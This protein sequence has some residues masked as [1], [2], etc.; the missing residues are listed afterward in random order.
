ML[1][2]NRGK[3][4]LVNFCHDQKKIYLNDVLTKQKIAQLQNMVAYARDE[5]AYKRLFFHFYPLLYKFA[6]AI[7]K[8]HEGAEE[9]VLD[10]T[11]QLWRLEQRLAY[12]E[13][14][15]TYLYTAT[16]NTAINYLKKEMRH[17]RIPAF[18]YYH[19]ETPIDSAINSELKELIEKCVND[20]P[21]QCQLVFR[22]I[23]EDGLKHKEVAEILAIS[24]NTVEGHMRNALK[25]LR[26][27]LGDYLHEKKS[28]VD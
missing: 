4:G 28:K 20:L 12:V 9:I 11:L 8:Q 25:K 23:K 17:S 22:L 13:N 5:G 6:I 10:V 2:Q 19:T 18:D 21:T 15:T 16:N 24:Q 26:I 1:L 3:V 14:L 27:G 7:C